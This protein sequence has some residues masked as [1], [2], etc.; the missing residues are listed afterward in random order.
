ML[1]PHWGI[2]ALEMAWP[3]WIRLPRFEHCHPQYL[4]FL[5]CQGSDVLQWAADLPSVQLVL[6]V[7]ANHLATLHNMSSEKSRPWWKYLDIIV[8]IWA[9]GFLRIKSIP[10]HSSETICVLCMIKPYTTLTEPW[11]DDLAVT[12]Q[13]LG[14]HSPWLNPSSLLIVQISVPQF[15]PDLNSYPLCETGGQKLLTCC[16]M[17]TA[18]GIGHCLVTSGHVDVVHTV[19]GRIR[20]LFWKARCEPPCS[21]E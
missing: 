1:G 12:A 20:A 2:T 21:L 15:R 11:Y 16:S 3:L 14:T 6:H 18:V 10:C 8:S 4:S 5:S 17:S 13:F 19:L 9:E 7:I